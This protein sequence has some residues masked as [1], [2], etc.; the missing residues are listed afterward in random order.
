MHPPPFALEE[1][2][3]CGGITRDTTRNEVRFFAEAQ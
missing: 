2:T 3:L 1:R